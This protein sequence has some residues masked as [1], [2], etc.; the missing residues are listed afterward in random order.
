VNVLSGWLGCAAPPEVAQVQA[1]DRFGRVGTGDTGDTG[2]PPAVQCRV[3]REEHD[4]DHIDY[5]Y[6][7]HPTYTIRT[8]TDSS[9]GT[10]VVE[11]FDLA[12]HAVSA[13]V[14]FNYSGMFNDSAGRLLVMRSFTAPRDQ[15]QWVERYEY[16]S[17]GRELSHLTVENQNIWSNSIGV[18]LDTN[19]YDVEDRR[20]G[21]AHDAHADG[22]LEGI[23]TL[24]YDADGLLV[25]QHD[26]HE[27]STP[28]DWNSSTTW[29]EYDER[30]LPTR[31]ELT[32]VYWN[33][34]PYCDFREY[35][36][37][38]RGDLVIEENVSCVSGRVFLRWT[39]TYDDQHRRTESVW[40]LIDPLHP[41]PDDEHWWW[42]YDEYGNLTS[43]VR[44][45]SGLTT[46][47]WTWECR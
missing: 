10:P 31:S 43:E 23:G 21:W 19:T 33:G 7:D 47:T 9:S 22:V 25:E 39:D 42:T 6:V 27:P 26:D 1:L 40:D 36:Y 28:S 17:A 38:D 12:G 3:L 8:A 45:Q 4:Y 37:D 16:D 44:E 18:F 5:T 15:S 30:G 34:D 2:A 13:W 41:G 32:G 20:V 29:W 35:T 24:T 46:T 11:T 14:A